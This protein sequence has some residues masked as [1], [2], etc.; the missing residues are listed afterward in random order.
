[1]VPQVVASGVGRSTGRTTSTVPE[2][3]VPVA[4]AHN[5]RTRGKSGF[6]QP[7]DCLNL[8]TAALS[9]VPT[10]VRTALSDPAWRLAMQAEFD[11]LQAN[12]T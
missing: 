3:I 10:S 12:D 8:N 11:A 9:P 4:N 6:W 1:M 2:A 7:V 5:M